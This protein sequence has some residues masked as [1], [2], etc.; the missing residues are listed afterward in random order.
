MV[1]TREG[2]VLSRVGGRYRVFD[3]G[4]TVLASIRGRMKQERGE[5]VLVGDWVTIDVHPN[6]SATIE[7]VKPRRS[8]LRRRSPGKAS[9]VRAVAANVDQVIVVGAA[10]NPDW[11]PQ[12]IDRFI[13]VAEANELPPVVV[14][15]KADLDPDAE[16]RLEPHRRAGYETVVTSGVNRVGLDRLRALLSHRVSLL[17]GPTGTGKSSLLNALQ[18]G[19]RLRTAPVSRRAG[20][21]RHT[22]VSAEMHPFA[23]GGFVVD[24]PG[25][26]DI[27]LWGVSPADVAAAFPE[28]ARFGPD[29]RFDNCRHLVE[30][31]CAVV[32][33]V[34]RGDLAATRLDSYRRLLAEASRAARPWR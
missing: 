27:G 22:T 29:C 6:G 28:F 24:T 12:L 3:A 19:L 21:G 9:G 5:R 31:E 33:A 23:G 2:I 34:E 17:A 11:D 15:N 32:A 4:E 20:T 7:G 14:I 25:L 13:A 30:P 26:R 10:R 16:S 1:T 18:P 8:L